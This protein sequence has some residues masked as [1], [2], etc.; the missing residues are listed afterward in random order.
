MTTLPELQEGAEQRFPFSHHET[1]LWAFQ[2]Y[3]M[4]SAGITL[5][6]S[7]ESLAKSALPRLSTACDELNSKIV[8]GR[9]LS[10]AMLSLRPTFSPLAINLISIGEHSGQLSSVLQR[11]SLRASRRD[12]M[13]RMLKSSLA[14]PV[15]LSTV[16]LGMALFM[17][18]Y[19]FPKILPFLVGLGVELPWPTR[20]LIWGVEHLSSAVLIVTIVLVG[21]V[22]LV[23]TSEESH[24]VRFREKLLFQTPLLGSLNRH[25]V[26]ADCFSDLHLL[27]EAGCDLVSSLKALHTNWPE[28]NARKERCLEELREGANF[29]EAVGSS[30]LFP[31]LFLLQLSTGEETGN[32]PRIF[33]MLSEQLDEAVTLRM[34][35]VTQILEPLMFAVMGM[36]TGFVVLATFLPMYGVVTTA[37]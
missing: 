4:L 13:E 23:V 8:Q 28:F 14:Y 17:A 34:S 11:L 1:H 21:V 37:L 7:L 16:S 36:V 3:V 2:L 27:L 6:S 12:K 5:V 20:A 30:E 15:F 29:V 35:Q 31:R 24:L 10:Q 9:S 33:E 18:F 32:L 22:R 26:Y 19:M 25:R